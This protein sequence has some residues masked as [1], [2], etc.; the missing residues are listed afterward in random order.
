M[1][2]LQQRASREPEDA[3]DGILNVSRRHFLRGAGG[4]ALG[5]YFAPLLGRFG[6]PQAAAAKAFEPNAFVRIA[7]DGTV[8]VIVVT[9]NHYFLDA[10]GGFFVLGVGYVTARIF[11]RAGRGPATSPVVGPDTAPELRRR[12]GSPDGSA[13]GT[14]SR[15]R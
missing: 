15:T 2:D 12:A 14:P 7:P 8:T 6:D 4:L 5:I 10:A 9:A 13:P 1:A 11:T 3:G